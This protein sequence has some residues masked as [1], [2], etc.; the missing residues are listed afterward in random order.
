MV[1]VPG[2]LEKNVISALA[3]GTILQ[4]NVHQFK[5]VNSVKNGSIPE[6]ENPESQSQ[7][8]RPGTPSLGFV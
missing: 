6:Q 8:Q 4:I 2:A 1:N 5:L 3:G 7:R